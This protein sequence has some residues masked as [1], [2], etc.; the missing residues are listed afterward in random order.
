MS[1]RTSHKDFAELARHFYECLVRDWAEFKRF[2][3]N[4]KSY[5]KNLGERL[6]SF[7]TLL[8]IEEKR[9]GA[10]IEFQREV[11]KYIPTARD[12]YK[13]L[14]LEIK[15]TQSKEFYDSCAFG[16]Y[17]KVRNSLNKLIL[18]WEKLAQ[19]AEG[20]DLKTTTIFREQA[21][22]LVALKKARDEA[23]MKYR[24]DVARR[25][26]LRKELYGLMMIASMQGKRIFRSWDKSRYK[27][28]FFKQ[29]P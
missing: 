21:L 1:Y 29:T 10:V 4:I 14:R 11:E 24:V 5:Y 17:R 12:A 25:D 23:E 13:A 20:R 3:P 27:D 2:D 18:F 9:A 15:E 22:N 16:Q 26:K 19:K 6:N 28:Y 8:N 7:S